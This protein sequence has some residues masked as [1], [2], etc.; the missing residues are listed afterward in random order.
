MNR[1]VRG[2]VGLVFWLLGILV[3]ISFLAG[4]LAQRA[5]GQDLGP[6][7]FGFRH[8]LNHDWYKNN[9]N[10]NGKH[11]CHGTTADRLGDC[12]PTFARKRGD[13]WIALVDG[14]WVPVPD[15]AILPKGRSEEPF[16]AHV[17]AQQYSKVIDCFFEKEGGT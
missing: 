5:F 10:K 14:E 11:C 6:G 16:M 8:H 12:R 15:Y 13:V 4:M 2:L 3:A 7:D 1:I 9:F 17:C